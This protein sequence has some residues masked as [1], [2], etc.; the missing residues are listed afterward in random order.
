MYR[1]CFFPNL[2][3]SLLDNKRILINYLTFEFLNLKIKVWRWI[4]GLSMNLWKVSN[5]FYR[6]QI[7]IIPYSTLSSPPPLNDRYFAKLGGGGLDKGDFYFPKFTFKKFWKKIWVNQIFKICYEYIN[8]NSCINLD[9][10]NRIRI[11]WSWSSNAI[12]I[13]NVSYI[14]LKKFWQLKDQLPKI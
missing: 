6:N 12:K 1:F 2:L 10:G 14:P 8:N 3:I 13:H 5:F 11:V 4:F 7:L 9:Y